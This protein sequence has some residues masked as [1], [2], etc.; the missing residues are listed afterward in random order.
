MSRQLTT[1]TNTTVLPPKNLRLL[2]SMLTYRRPHGSTAEQLFC[3]KFIRPTGAEQDPFGNWHLWLPQPDGSPSPIL[4]SSHTDTVHQSPGKQ[5]V[6]WNPYGL[7]YL[8][9]SSAS[10]CLGADNTA[11]VWLMLSMAHRRVPGHYIWHRA[12][13]CG[14]LGSKWLS[15]KGQA[16]LANAKCAIAFDRRGTGSII[17]HQMFRTCSDSFAQ[18]LAATIG[19]GHIPDPTGIF[20]DTA[21][22]TDHIGE[23]TN[24]SIGTQHEHQASETLNTTYLLALR[25]ALCKA[26]FSNLSYSRQ[27]GDPDDDRGDYW[28]GWQTCGNSIGNGYGTSWPQLRYKSL[29]DLVWQRPTMVADF[30]EHQGFTQEELEQWEDSIYNSSKG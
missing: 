9:P 16:Y 19:L 15:G 10:N 24:I 29:D 5:T 28:A 11:G 26:N 18:S 21:N 1:T 17:T 25:N 14:G 12:E 8:H 30:L 6:S 20:T 3:D 13:E 2:L 23:C 22:Y 7:A 4:W 27:P